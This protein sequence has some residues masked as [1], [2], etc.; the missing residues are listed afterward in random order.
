M[1]CK[2][3]FC[4]YYRKERCMTEDI[5]INSMGMCEDF[6]CVEFDES[7][8]KVKRADLLTKIER[9]YQRLACHE[10][11]KLEEIQEFAQTFLE[12]HGKDFLE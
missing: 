8:L 1:R 4:I 3:K 2:N 5:A 10:N 11:I 7:E 6:V 12:E 9:Q